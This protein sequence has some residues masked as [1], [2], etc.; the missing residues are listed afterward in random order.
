ML[1]PTYYIPWLGQGMTI[2]LVAVV[3]VLISHGFAIG[4]LSVVVLLEHLALRRGDPELEDLAQRMLKPT[5]VIV[6]AVGAVTG[7]G[8]WFAVSALA[9]GASAACSGFFSGPGSLSGWPSPSR[10]WCC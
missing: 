2:G 7:T 4:V 5:V 9:P 6:T 1:F 8:I 3:H 10:W